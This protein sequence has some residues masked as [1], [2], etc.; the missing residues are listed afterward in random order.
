MIPRP[1]RSTLFPYTTLF[2]FFLN[3]FLA[4]MVLACAT[5]IMLVILSFLRP[6]RHVFSRVVRAETEKASALGET[7]FGIKT[8]KS[9]ALEP[10]RRALWDTRVAD[11]ATWRLAF[12]KLTNWP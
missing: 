9:L 7:V 2:R 1:P 3:T 11:A 10:Q 12:G 5:S 4:W 6:L 8:I